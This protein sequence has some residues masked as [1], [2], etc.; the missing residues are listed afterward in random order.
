MYT[1][2]YAVGRLRYG[3]PGIH[4]QNIQSLPLNTLST[5]FA[6]L[7]IVVTDQTWNRL[8]TLSLDD[9]AATFAN[10]SGDIDQFLTDNGNTALKYSLIIPK[11]EYVYVRW[12][13][14]SHK[15]FYT[16]PGNSALSHDR[17]DKLLAESA[18]DIRLMRVDETF[19]GYKELSQKALYVVNGGF[20]RTLWDTSALY[21]KGAGSDYSTFKRDIYVSALNFEKI[22]SI[23]TLP[24]TESMITVPE[25]KAGRALFIDL[26]KDITLKNK[27]V[28]LVFNGQLL[29]DE[30]I[31]TVTGDRTVLFDH[32]YVNAL[33]HYLTYK[34]ITRV[35]DFTRQDNVDAYVKASLLC[36]NSF[37]VVIDNP[38]VGVELEPL[39][40]FA[41]PMNHYTPETFTHPVM[42]ENGLFPYCYRR[43]Y[44]IDDRVINTD[45]PH[46]YR[47]VI[48]TTGQLSSPR[49]YTGVNKGD[50]GSLPRAFMVKI[51]ALAQ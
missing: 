35:V 24:I 44:G 12:E 48:R 18:P 39:V 28:W 6:S 15:G 2:E 8:C 47:P 20:V 40:K 9:Y 46:L 25:E 10:Y 41:Y 14:L 7:R 17:Q 36:D 16:Y 4:I 32:G 13:S 26:N 38:G 42:L 31:I 19:T 51:T 30:D 49:V 43:T 29:V 50:V 23:A 21:L 34:D 45:I 37:L 3:P 27:T 33:Y 11:K 1:Y 5:Q 22:G